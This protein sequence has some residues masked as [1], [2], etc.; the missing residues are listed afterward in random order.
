MLAAICVVGIY[1]YYDRHIR[2]FQETNDARIEADQ[3]AISSKL[4]GYVQAVPVEDNQVV[5]KGTLLVRIDPL[6][7][8]TR[9]ASADADIAS[10][11]A[12]E[13]AARASVAESKAM[14]SQAAAG[15]EASRARL[16]LAQREAKR[17][18]PL[19][20][21][22]AEPKARLSQLL[23]ERDGAQ[24]EVAAHVAALD[25]ARKRVESLS[26]Q[27]GSLAAQR[28][29]AQVQRR[30]AANDLDSTLIRSPI[31]GTVGSRTVRVGQYVQPG[32]RLMTV[33][34]TEGIYVVANFKETQVGLMRPGQRATIRVD[35]LP[36][37][38]FKGQVT[39]VTPGTGANFSLI[40]PENATGNF[41][42]IVQR[43]PV[44]IRIDAGSRARKV[45]VPGLSAEVEVDTRA[46]RD[47]I[48]AIREEQAER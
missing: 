44:R 36:G 16:A 43:V 14:V 8:R 27:A 25:Q 7:L 39:S 37:V 47:D 11:K 12:A 46:S 48:D 17:Y 9:L 3:V 6:D 19:V 42:K 22:G 41:T 38:E 2:Y 18:G 15:L 1:V 40:K 35:A 4:A 28:E 33:V 34:P 32:Q 10:A 26:A 29:V 13:A 23:A 20:D 30:A 5:S 45:L 24:A 21:A 31:A